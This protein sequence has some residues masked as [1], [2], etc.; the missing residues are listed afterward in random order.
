MQ[1][2]HRD[3]VVETTNLWHFFQGAARY[4][5]WTSLKY[6][7]LRVIK[8][9]S[10]HPEN[11][12]RILQA[13]N[14]RENY[15]VLRF[16]QCALWIYRLVGALRR[17]PPFSD[18]REPQRNAGSYFAVASIVVPRSHTGTFRYLIRDVCNRC[19]IY[20]IDDSFKFR[21][22]SR[23]LDRRIVLKQKGG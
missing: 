7:R 9:F 6:C 18:P 4:R 13:R 22:N 14:I 16:A 11:I 10:Y 19:Q 23:R 20:F 3:K 15:G 1:K 21:T 12:G 17:S 2:T 5:K 8:V